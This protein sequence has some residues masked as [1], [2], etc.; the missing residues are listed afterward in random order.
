V[1]VIGEMLSRQLRIKMVIVYK[2]W[3]IVRRCQQ[4]N[5]KVISPLTDD[6][7]LISITALVDVAPLH[8]CAN[9]Y[10]HLVT[11]TNI[12]PT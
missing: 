2:P 8:D 10:I 4:W 1:H 7:G 5:G 6:K 9:V 11:S 3:C 12:S